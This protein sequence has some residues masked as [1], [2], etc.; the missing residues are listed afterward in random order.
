MDLNQKVFVAQIKSSKC[1][2]G[3]SMTAKLGVLKIHQVN[4]FNL[5]DDLKKL[6]KILQD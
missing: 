5:S 1:L 3:S 6:S 4:E 2:V